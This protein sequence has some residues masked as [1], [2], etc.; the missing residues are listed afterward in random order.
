M[1]DG[2]QRIG[3]RY[4]QA[5]TGNMDASVITGRGVQA[6]MGGFDNQ[7]KAGQD[8]FAEGFRL[9]FSLAL[10]LDQTYWPN[11]AKTIRGVSSGTPYE[12]TYKPSRDINGAFTVDVAYGLLAGLDPNRALVWGLQA[13]GDKLISR[14]R[15]RRNL[16]IEGM[17]VTQEEQA[18]DIE[19]MRDALK[20]ALAGDVQAIPILAQNGVDPA[21]KIAQV[22]K[23]IMARRQGKSIEEAIALAYTPEPPPEAAPGSEQPPVPGAP[24]SD[25]ASGG[26]PDGMNPDGTIHGVYPGMQGQAPGGR[27]PLEM[28]L[29]GLSG[30]GKPNLQANI[31]R[32]NAIA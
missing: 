17:D 3:A 27:P 5:R 20:Q 8:Q 11:E 19:D 10:E 12:L 31:S 32:R 28:L 16:P 23:A 21:G 30:S 26:T 22:A 24:G 9:I 29:A 25:A 15:L 1:L 4:P 6:L 7:I 2:E 14:S 18:I 13:R